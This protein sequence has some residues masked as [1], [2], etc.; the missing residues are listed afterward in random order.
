MMKFYIAES[1]IYH[2]GDKG[3]AYYA[4]NAEQA[5]AIIKSKKNPWN[6]LFVTVNNITRPAYV[7]TVE[8]IEE[9]MRKGA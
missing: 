7:W 8:K 2:R 5:S 6:E 9:T 4:D 1:S 3:I